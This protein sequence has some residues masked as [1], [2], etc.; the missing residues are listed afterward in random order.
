MPPLMKSTIR[1]TTSPLR[2]PARDGDVRLP[3]PIVDL[4][5]GPGGLGEGFSS[6]SVSGKSF[7]R[8]K[9]SVEKEVSAHQTLELRS[10][11]RQFP[12]AEVPQDYYRFLRGE[13]DRKKLFARY[14]TQSL[15]ARLE[16]WCA[17]LGSE[18]LSAQQLDARIRAAIGGH[19][20]WVLIGGPPCQAYS[21][22]GRSRNK[23]VS[24]RKMDADPRHFLY[25]E[26]LRVLGTHWPAVFVMENVT[27]ILSSK[28]QGQP[29]FDRILQDL[30]NPR[31]ALSTPQVGH[32]GYE[33]Y[34]IYSLVQES[35]G[36]DIFGLP[37]HNPGAYVIESERYGIP[38]AR[39]R[40][41]LLGVR[42]DIPTSPPLLTPAKSPVTARHVL[43]GLP[44]LR[45][46]L[47][48][49]ID[50]REE[51]LAV[52]RES[53][54]EPW[55]DEV[56]KKA[57]ADVLHLLIKTA[58][59][60]RAPL[61]DR[62]GEF[63]PHRATSLYWGDWYL[64]D[65]IQ[66]VCN[67]T[68]RAHV[69]EDVYRYLYAA[70]Y[71]TVHRK[72]PRLSDFPETLYPDHRNISES[73]GHNN[74]ADRFR[75]QLKDEPSTTVVSHIAKDGHYYIH[76]DPTQCRS[77]TVREAARLQTFPDNY[78]FC[79]NRTAQYTQV[80]NAVPPLLAKQIAEVVKTFY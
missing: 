1:T 69:T 50:S 42:H 71:A 27:G 22:A 6:V 36:F 60:L 32:A 21:V 15:A 41:I 52:I 45:S 63:V 77:L 51:W 39:H 44:R 75:V 33:G 14:P 28:V 40:V 68:T 65:R 12:P 54:Q 61:H 26:Y 17:E 23:H 10:F 7:F 59:H 19:S 24:A 34:R 58:Q 9:L 78:F 2:R 3:V 5:A 11:F 20:N 72:S 70:C 79:G 30:Q 31:E 8:L 55:F 57:G 43:E 13:I 38:Q 29:I 18:A 48:H 53:P 76:Y 74:F 62:G 49:A 64:D 80:G 25:R 67:S 73:L 47:S 4:F 16:A 66:G 35:Q 37:N 56:R 46:G